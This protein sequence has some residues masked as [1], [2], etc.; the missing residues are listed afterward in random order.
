MRSFL[1]HL[2]H[3]LVLF[4]ILLAGFTGLVLFSYD[5]IFQIA[6]ASALVLSYVAWGTI[7]HYLDRDLH[8]ETIVEYLVVA[9]LGF[10]I[11]I[12]LVIRS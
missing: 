12:S 10:V 4:G 6:V 5:K 9:I 11:I 7:H 2:S 8:F 1:R 3:Y